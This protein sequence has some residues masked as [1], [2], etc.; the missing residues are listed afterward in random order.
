M[1]D[2]NLNKIFGAFV[3]FASFITYFLTVQSTTSF[4]DCGEFIASAHLLQVPH[5]PGT[6]FFLLLGRLF[7]MIPLDIN[8]GLKVNMISVFSSAFTVLFLYLSAVLLTENYKKNEEKSLFNSIVTYSAAAIGALSLAFADTFWFN[9][10]E[11]EVYGLALFFATFIF[12]LALLWNKNSEKEGNEKYLLLIAYLL[13][14][15]LGV[16]LYAVLAIIPIVMIVMFKKYLTDEKILM[17]TGKLFAIHSLI[18]LAIAVIGWLN[19]SDSNPPSQAEFQKIDRQFL[20]AFG[21]GSLIFMGI[22]WKKIFQ[23]GSFYYAM[24]AGALIMLVVYPGVIKYIPKIIHLLGQDSVGFDLLLFVVIFA[25]AGYLAYWSKKNEKRTINLLAKSFLLVLIGYSSYFM[26]IIRAN[27]DTPINLNSPKTVS[28]L[29]KYINREQYGTQPTFKRRWSQESHQLHIYK[30]YDSDFDFWSRYQ[31]H[32]MFNRYLLWNYSGRDSTVQ[33][34]QWNFSKLWGIPFLLGIIGFLIHFKKDWRM[35]SVLLVFFLFMGYLMAYYSNMQQPQPRERD[36]FAVGAFFVFSIWIALGV[37]GIADSI[38]EFKNKNAVKPAIAALL[39][40]CVVLVPVKMFAESYHRNDRSQNYIPWDYAYNMLQSVEKDAILFTNGDNDTFPLW[41]LQDVEGVRRDVRIANLS[42]I[43]TS[44]YS[45]QLKN[46][47]PYGSKK[48]KMSYTD[49]QLDQLRP[50]LWEPKIQAIKLT[51]EA[52]AKFGITDTAIINKG[53]VEWLMK[54]TQQW[55][56]NKAIVPQDILVRDIIQTNKF[57]RPVYFAVTCSDKSMIGLDNYLEM[58]GLALKVTPIEK[59]QSGGYYRLNIPILEKQLMEEPEGYATE[60]SPGFKFRSLDNPEVFLDANH[61]RMTLNYRNGYLR[62]AAKYIYGKADKQRGLEILDK[63][64]ENIPLERVDMP[65]FLQYYYGSLLKSAG[66][67]E[68]Y[69]TLALNLEKILIA[70]IRKNP[71][72]F[73][74]QGNPYQMLFETYENLEE[75]QKA[76]DLAKALKKIIPNDKGVDQLIQDYTKRLNKNKPEIT[77]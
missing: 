54:N 47:T 74:R 76:I 16:H 24:I 68:K 12:W 17:S 46:T 15:S 29:V 52:A 64:E 65:T 36:Y 55:G 11:A 57:E 43:N 26:I 56:K 66:A 23:R 70:E 18:M 3:F 44:W 8:T 49:R 60:Y 32:H 71:R 34:A 41:Y 9:A 10:V 21:V 20:I 31:M 42:L 58:E 37:R 62:L 50:M 67:D 51:K 19:L 59:K 45:K 73:S 1:T 39:V 63:M 4:W 75:Y 69:R 25:G 27:H 22:T 33:D 61:Q 40:L 72:N 77:K 2:K 13:G 38:M 14:I 30:N 5:P 6:P 53:K 7:S 48:V 28:E 35:A